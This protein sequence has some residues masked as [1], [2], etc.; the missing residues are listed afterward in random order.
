M[1]V[2]TAL[3]RAA[4]G[5]VAATTLFLNAPVSHAAPVQ[6]TTCD[7][8]GDVLSNSFALDMVC[9]GDPALSGPW[10]LTGTDDGTNGA[11]NGFNSAN[12]AQLHGTYV[13][14]CVIVNINIT[15]CLNMT[16]QVCINSV[17]VTVTVHVCISISINSKVCIEVRSGTGKAVMLPQGAAL[18]GTR[19][20]VG[21]RAP[22][23]AG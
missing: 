14:I 23:R 17:C 2:T 11:V 10:H 5:F 8:F 15:I 16:T 9:A 21:A 3:R 13:K 12:G 6:P 1:N 22:A 18:S 4:I 19:R 7:A 20:R